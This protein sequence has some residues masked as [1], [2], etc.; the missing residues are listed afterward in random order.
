MRRLTRRQRVAAFVL[1]AVALGFL[2]LDLGGNG[3]RSSHD[4]VR[5]SLGALY[6]GTDALLGPVRRWVQGLPSAG[7]NED[8]V[9]ALRHQVADLERQLASRDRDTATGAALA[10]LQLASDSGQFRILPARVVALGPGQGFDWT[11]TL[12]AG[13]SDGVR[14]GQTVTDGAALVGRVLRADRSSC[15]V[16]LGADPG[17]GVGVRDARTGQIGIAT[18]EG[19]SGYRF[20]PLDP[21]AKLEVG[22]RLVTGPTGST[23]FVAGLAVGTVRSVRTSADGTTN[24]EV[25]PATSP[26]QLDLVG[27]ILVGGEPIPTREPLSPSTPQARR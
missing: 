9:H 13:T 25:R 11:V 23:S 1:A 21:T 16:L 17:A 5:G 2:T 10:R 4:G 24:A 3:L 27:V 6:R 18:G 22:D 8:R 15:V 19:T 26:T 14:V 20:V 7:S 12:D